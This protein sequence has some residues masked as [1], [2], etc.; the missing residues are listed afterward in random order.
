MKGFTSFK[1]LFILIFYLK[2]NLQKSDCQTGCNSLL[3]GTCIQCRSGYCLNSDSCCIV[4][5]K[6]CKTCPDSDICSSC[7]DSYYLSEG[8]CLPCSDQNCKTCNNSGLVCTNCLSGYYL[9]NSKCSKCDSN[10]YACYNSADH[11][12]SCRTGYYLSNS[13]CYKCDSNCKTCSISA[14]HCTSCETGYYVSNSK[15]YQCDSNCYTCYNSAE[16]CTSCRTGYYLNSNFCEEC[17]SPC[18]KCSS[19]TKCTDCIVNYFLASDKCYQCNMNCKAIIDNCKC[20]NCYDGYYLSN[21]QCLKCDSN[22]KTCSNSASLCLSCNNGYYLKSSSCEKCI[23]PCQNCTSSIK[24]TDCI[25]NYFL[26]SD[27]CYQCNMNCNET[28]DNCKCINCYD[29]YYLSNYQCLKCD[30]NCKTCSNSSILCSS[31]YD[32]YY[33]NANA[34]LNCTNHCKTCI[35]ESLCTSCID[36]YFLLSDKCYQCNID[37]KTTSDGCQCSSC[38]DGYYLSNSQCLKCADLNCKTCSGSADNCLICNEDFY[39]DLNNTYC[40][41]CS[42]PCNSCSNEN[43]CISCRYEYNDTCYKK[44]PNHTYIL[45]GKESYECIEKSLNEYYYFD[46]ENE[47]YKKCYETCY[48][49]DFGGNKTNHNCLECKE[50]YEFYINSK[51]IKNCYEKCD[52]FYYF[53]ELNQFHCENECKGLYNKTIIEKKACIDECNKDDTYMY[54]YNNTCYYECP[55]WTITIKENYTCIDNTKIE[56]PINESNIEDERDKEL[57][58][59]RQSI[60]DFDINSNQQDIINKTDNVQYQIT[61]SNKNN[62]NKNMSSIDLGDCEEKLK[63]VYDIDRSLPLIFFKIDYFSPDSLIPIIG[64]EI[65][66]PITKEKLNLS[67]CEDILIKLNIPVNIDENNLFKYDPN[68]EFYKDNCFSYTTINGTDIILT[69]RKQEFSENNLSLC[70]NNCN[71]EG[72]DEENKQSTCNC[73]IKNKMD[74]ISEIM[75]NPIQL[76]NDFD[77]KEDDSSS[78]SSNIVSI[79]CTKALF[80]K[81]GLKNNISSYIIIIFIIHFLLSIALFIKCGYPLLL[82]DINKIIQEKN[83]KRNET[84]IEQRKK[85]KSTKDKKKKKFRK[86]KK[87]KLKFVNNTNTSKIDKDKSSKAKILGVSNINNRNFN[88][89]NKKLNYI[90]KTKNKNVHDKSLSNKISSVTKKKK[91]NDFELNSFE[92]KEALLI[93][94]RTCVEYYLALIKYKNVIIFSFCPRNDYNSIIIRSCIFSLSFSIHYAINFVFFTDEIMHKIY[95][96][97]GKYDILYFI[98]QISISFFVSYYFTVIIKIIFLSERNIIQVRKQPSLS[99]SYI[100]SDKVKKNLVIKYAVFF[101]LGLIFLVFFWMLLSSFGAVYTNTQMFIFKNTLVSF[102]MSLLYPFIISI[103]PSV[104]RICSLKSKNSEYIYKVSKYL[105]IL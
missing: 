85:S 11:C 57:A 44:C 68:S 37:C 62:T 42:K 59:F 63:S 9:S 71:Y 20:I 96:E 103:F 19:N 64:Y 54:E 78:A 58:R 41:Q 40:I 13:K 91:Y 8:K 10:C 27:K 5:S 16:H 3:S 80:S 26:F 88:L 79:K 45:D 65:Y 22:C 15:C 29:G 75:Q 101:I 77:P 36:N 46:K 25:E 43:M 49:C 86:D 6:S 47:I 81:D 18:K 1:F 82:G 105:Q 95:E 70:E 69:D 33:L 14:D 50:N 39:L 28:I 52:E 53:D 73:N 83:P 38:N 102:A 89:K 94:G 55:K 21:Y 60:S 74:T 56:K 30:S 92:Y 97:G 76:S 84:L 100:A 12:T 32:G 87:Y 4:T 23:S 93:D 7:Q 24:C 72:Y 48:R 98:P 2:F 66:H 61:T 34:C 51:N 90:L 99:L 31:C 17:I 104:L 67:H 35:N